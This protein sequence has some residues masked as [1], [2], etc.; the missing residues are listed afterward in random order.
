[1]YITAFI[2]EN[3]PKVEENP[4]HYLNKTASGRLHRVRYEERFFMRLIEKAGFEIL[5]YLH[6]GIERTQQS[7]VVARK[8]T[9]PDQVTSTGR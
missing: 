4:T 1:L 5:E 9:P 3:V 2:E 7:V 8:P 6:Q